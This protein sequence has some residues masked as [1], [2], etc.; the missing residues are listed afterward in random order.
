MKFAHISRRF[1]FPHSF[2]SWL[3]IAFMPAGVPSARALDAQ[4]TYSSYFG[5]SSSDIAMVVRTGPDGSTYIAGHTLSRTFPFAVSTNVFQPSFAGGSVNGDA[6]VARFDST[7][8]NLVY[9]TYIGGRYE[10]GALD[11]AVDA[12]GNAYITGFTTSDDFPV[13]NAIAPQIHGRRHPKLRTF[14]R[15]AFVCV[16]NPSGTDL[17]YSTYLGGTGSDL[18]TAIAV[19]STG[20]ACVT[21][22]T[23]STNF[24]T[25]NPLPGQIKRKG[26]EDAFVTK[27]APDG[28]SYV[29]STYLGGSRK[30]V[31]Q[32]I[33]V[34]SQNF[35]HLTGYTLS[36]DF[37]I[38]NAFQTMIN[39]VQPNSGA[40]DAWIAKLTDTGA[41]L[42][43]TFLGNKQSDL[44][45]RI[46]TDAANAAYVTG[47]TTS[48]QFPVTLTNT[49][50]ITN[51]RTA[52]TANTDAFLC[53]IVTNESG[54]ATLAYSG[55]MGGSFSDVG[56]DVAVTPGGDAYVVGI[57]T[58]RNFPTNNINGSL[59]SKNSG[60][61]DVFVFAL[62]SDAQSVISSGYFGGSRND[63]AYGI[64]LTPL[65][66][67]IAGR[68]TSLNFP[69]ANPTQ[70]NRLGASDA[71]ISILPR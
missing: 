34:D 70:T 4:A 57:T 71:F 15:D 27:I 13:R 33:A 10:D 17:I 49:P 11:L 53:K 18:A 61:A 28:Q 42:Y 22:F 5:G 59:S 44:G 58:S 21:G 67:V 66:L 19:D 23:L 30:D 40:Y 50:G 16:L 2:L 6:F 65:D 3:I 69:T 54:S 45:Y 43:S 29:F 51:A 1:R 48:R 55:V 60:N 31:A 68:T 24:P 25:S 32:G 7:G 46:A 38:T 14:Q 62:A 37:P 39:Q 12:A 8:S 35:I 52:R 20:A 63:Y 9:F 64:A 41:L 47:Y 26:A 36:S 56:W